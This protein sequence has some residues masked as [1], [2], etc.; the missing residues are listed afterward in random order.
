MPTEKYLVIIYSRKMGIW[1]RSNHSTMGSNAITDQNQ[2][3]GEKK[4]GF[5]YQVGRGWRTNI[6][7]GNNVER[8]HCQPLSVY[9]RLCFTG[10]HQSRP[11]GTRGTV[12]YWNFI[13]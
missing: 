9:K 4:A 1:T 5:P 12:S 13:H 8:G 7:F 6:A 10:V 3:G 11:T 2:G